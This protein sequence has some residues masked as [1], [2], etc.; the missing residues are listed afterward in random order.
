MSLVTLALIGL[1]VLFLLMIF[2]MPISTSMFVVGFLGLLVVAS[3]RAAFSVLTA[4]LWNQFS[5]YTMSV[6]PL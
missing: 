6:I 4:D 3:P 1:A 2:R 5:S